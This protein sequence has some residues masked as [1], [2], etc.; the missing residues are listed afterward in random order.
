MYS[1]ALEKC[2]TWMEQWRTVKAIDLGEAWSNTCNQSHDLLDLS[3]DPIIHT[4]DSLFMLFYSDMPYL[5]CA[6]IM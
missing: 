2:I 4:L 3:L 5:Q 6:L 1:I